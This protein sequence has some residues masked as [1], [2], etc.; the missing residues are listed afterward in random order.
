MDKSFENLIS[1]FIENRIGISNDFLSK[2]LSSHL[3]SNVL[4]LQNEQALFRAGIGNQQ[5]FIQ[6]TEVRKDLVYWLDKVHGNEYENMF[7]NLIDD[8]IKYLNM[9]CYA[10][11]TSCEFHYSIYE[12]GGFYKRHLDQ[13][14]SNSSREYSM[15]SYLNSD[16]K[17]EDGGELCVYQKDKAIYI[18]P[19]EGKTVFFKSNELEHEVLITNQK[20]LSVTGWFKCD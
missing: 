17:T 20:R 3:K 16:W 2:S 8:F 9:T 7:L 13:F 19:L 18:Q 12:V 1:S 5:K 15:V 11:I 4:Q 6:I 14:Q 10:G